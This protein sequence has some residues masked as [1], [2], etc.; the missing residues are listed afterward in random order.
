MWYRIASSATLKAINDWRFMSTRA[1]T[2]GP[3]VTYLTRIA[4]SYV[5]VQFLQVWMCSDFSKRIK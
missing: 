3:G 1:N 4:V 2:L 5:M